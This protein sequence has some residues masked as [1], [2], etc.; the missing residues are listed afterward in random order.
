MQGH[1]QSPTLLRL[2]TSSSYYQHL[3]KRRTSY[4]TLHSYVPFLFGTFFYAQLLYL[5]LSSFTEWG[6][7]DYY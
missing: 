4:E 7:S 3:Q 6:K 5:A 1:I 2:N